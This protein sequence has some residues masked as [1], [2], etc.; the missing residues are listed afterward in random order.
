MISKRRNIRG[1]EGQGKRKRQRLV[2]NQLAWLLV[3]NRKGVIEAF[4]DAGFE[5]DDDASP[6]KLKLILRKAVLRLKEKR[7]P[8][9]KALIRNISALILIEQKDK[10]EE[11][12]NFFNR[13]KDKNVADADSDS[14][15]DEDKKGDEKK[16]GDFLKDNADSIAQI[17]TAI[18]GGL[19]NRGGNE[20]VDS[21]MQ[22]YQNQQFDNQP[23]KSKTGL[24]IGIGVGAIAVIGLTAFLIRRSRN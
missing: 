14:D 8:K 7:S 13:K 21:Q 3:N 5:V 2:L 12:A 24:I 10:T 20:Q 15:S 4:R 19:F 23:K 18:F 9:A 1:V 17:G 22:T 11:F 16:K 6:K